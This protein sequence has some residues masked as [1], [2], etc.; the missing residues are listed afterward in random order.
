MKLI[1]IH[2]SQSYLY[3]QKA[4][5]VITHQLNLPALFHAHILDTNALSQCRGKFCTGT[6]ESLV[7]KSLRLHH[8]PFQ[9]RNEGWSNPDSE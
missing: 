7:N 3:V 8:Q 9:V 4:G 1:V 5:N 6:F 2:L